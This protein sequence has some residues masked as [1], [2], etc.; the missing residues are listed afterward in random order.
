MTPAH[1]SRRPAA[2]AMTADS[3]S[4]FPTQHVIPVDAVGGGSGRDWIRRS[5]GETFSGNAVRSP[6]ASTSSAQKP[7]NTRYAKPLLPHDGGRSLSSTTTLPSTCSPSSSGSFVKS[8]RLRRPASSHAGATTGL[9]RLC[10]PCNNSPKVF[11]SLGALLRRTA[12]RASQ[13]P[14]DRRCAVSHVTSGHQRK[15]FCNVRQFCDR[16]H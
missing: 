14:R 5:H 10:S 12:N 8:I 9:P 13:E 1:G 4:R 16:A 15:A 6:T 11:A 2:A 7:Y 3:G